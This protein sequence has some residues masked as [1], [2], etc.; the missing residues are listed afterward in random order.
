MDYQRLASHWANV[1]QIRKLKKK[2]TFNDS[3]NQFS[4]IRFLDKNTLP[5][6]D[7]CCNYFLRLHFYLKL[8]SNFTQNLMMCDK[9]V[10]YT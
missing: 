6:L 1:Q 2:K 3:T 7:L 9:D 8:K 5:A 4:E 10:K